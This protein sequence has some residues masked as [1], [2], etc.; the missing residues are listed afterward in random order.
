MEIESP[1]AR[2]A[3]I[4]EQFLARFP[5]G[6]DL[7]LAAD[8][9]LAARIAAD[10]LLVAY[11]LD[12]SQAEIAMRWR[13]IEADRK[14]NDNGV[15]AAQGAFDARI[16]HPRIVDLLVAEL[17]PNEKLV[18]V[19]WWKI[20]T[21]LRTRTYHELKQGCRTVTETSDVFFERNFESDQTRRAA[22]E[23]ENL[24]MNPPPLRYGRNTDFPNGGRP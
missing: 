22:E 2:I 24:R 1:F 23:A 12:I 4:R 11:A 21:N 10:P 14:A 20:E 13:K 6:A 9:K 15:K 8:E 5:D 7:V 19:G 3:R 16:W 17:K 18:S